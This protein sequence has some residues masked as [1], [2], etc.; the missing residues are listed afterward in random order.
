MSSQISMVPYQYPFEVA[1]FVF[2][3]Q[4][5]PSDPKHYYPYMTQPPQPTQG[6]ISP[7]SIE[8]LP[9]FNTPFLSFSSIFF[10][11]KFYLLF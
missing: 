8:V 1:Q 9:T 2:S 3:D 11:V 5:D 7:Y 6:F 4:I 10:L